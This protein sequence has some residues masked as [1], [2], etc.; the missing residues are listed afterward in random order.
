MTFRVH[1]TFRAERDVDHILSFIVERSPQ[2]AATWAARWH[3]VLQELSET[4]NQKPIAP[5]SEDH[6]HEIHHVVFKTRRGKAY[7][8]I[9]IIQDDLVLIT[10]V[11]GPGQDIVPPNDAP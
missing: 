8:A 5:E 9:F 3:E 4:A 11:R 10:H 7:R 2:G 6:D 1:L